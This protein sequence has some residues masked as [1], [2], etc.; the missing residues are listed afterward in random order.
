MSGATLPGT[1]RH[2]GFAS[3]RDAKG[4]CA[5]CASAVRISEIIVETLRFTGETHPKDINV[6]KVSY[7]IHMRDDALI[8]RIHIHIHYGDQSIP[9]DRTRHDLH[10]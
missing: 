5:P 1:A 8:D 6:R 9:A 10:A 2:I 4:R 3:R 7:L